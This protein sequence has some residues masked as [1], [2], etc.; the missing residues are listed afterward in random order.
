MGRRTGIDTIADYASQLGLGEEMGLEIGRDVKKGFIATPESYM[1]RQQTWQ[2]GN[3]I[4]A[5]IGQA[6][7]YVTPLQMAAQAMTIGNKG[8]RYQ[9]Y[10]VDSIYDYGME[11]LISK[12]EPVVAAEIEDKTGFTFDTVIEGMREAAQFD[13]YTYPT[14]EDYYTDNY[15]LTD[16]PYDVAIKTGTP[17][18][19]SSTDTG[20][21]F[22]GFYPADD[23]E[24]AFSGFIEHGEYS[25]LMI[26]EIISAYYDEFYTI[27]KLSESKTEEEI[28]EELAGLGENEEE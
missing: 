4:Q 24:I 13:E 9:T 10:M 19:T 27:D 15:L 8:T 6:D 18:I 16:L 25:K 12:T 17:Q 23:P 21:A 22:I 26:K 3:V 7:T 5:A 28:A 2:A 11:N 14:T 1:E 20:S